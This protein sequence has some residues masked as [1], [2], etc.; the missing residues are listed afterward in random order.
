MAKG[1]SK[2]V[3]MGAKAVESGAPACSFCGKPHSQVARLVGGPG[4]YICDACVGLCNGILADESN[5]APAPGWKGWES[6]S[7][8]DLLASL[9]GTLTSVEHVREG[10][11]ARIDE[12]R[13]REVSWA[14]IGDVLGMSR[15]A[16]WER[17]S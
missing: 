7:D 15:Q 1:K 16:A 3:P 10:L 2:G 14:R 4:V 17:F 5:Q 11:Q 8:D 12:L 6:M 13:R 9:R